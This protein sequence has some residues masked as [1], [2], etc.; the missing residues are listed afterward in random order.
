ME[1]KIP[2]TK[3]DG[4]REQVAKVESLDSRCINYLGDGAIL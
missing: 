1:I 3:L 4:E 2:N